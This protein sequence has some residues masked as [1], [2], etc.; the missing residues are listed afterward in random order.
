MSGVMTAVAVVGAGSSLYASKMQADAATEA[1]ELQAGAAN[2]ASQLQYKTFQQQQALMDPWVN[3]G[4]NA[5]ALLQYQMFGVTPSS[6]TMRLDPN[7]LAYQTALRTNPNYANQPNLALYQNPFTGAVTA[8]VPDVSR[9]LQGAPGSLNPANFTMDDFRG[10]LESQVYGGARDAAAKKS[11]DATQAQGVAQ[12]MGNLNNSG[13]IQNALMQNLGQLYA[14]Y[15]PQ[16]LSAW[17]ANKTNQFN[18]MS[19]MASPQGAQQVG[20]YAGNM[21]SNVGNNMISA[22]NAVGQGAVNRAG[23][24]DNGIQNLSN[25][26][27]GAYG[28]YQQ[29]QMYEK[30]L[31]GLQ[32]QSPSI[33]IPSNPFK[34]YDTTLRA[35]T[36]TPIK[37]GN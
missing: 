1:A 13:N 25:I 37:L 19:G 12:G 33:S 32:S 31:E 11:I 10:S 5:N 28:Q 16:A 7:S 20:N 22:G 34:N 30:Y 2:N 4:R 21:A 23:A 9:Y 29:N 18:M 8:E 17:Q 35:P 6:D 24:W 27:M 36:S 26:G 3:S 15:D 14:Q